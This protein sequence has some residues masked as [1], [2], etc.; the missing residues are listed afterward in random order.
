MARDGITESMARTLWTL[1]WA[2]AED[3]AGRSYPGQEL[4]QIAPETPPEAWDAALILV[5]EFREANDVDSM[6]ILMMRAAR[7]DAKAAGASDI[8]ERADELAD[9]R[10]EEEFG[11]CMAMEAM[12]HGVSW[13][14]THASFD[15]NFPRHPFE[16]SIDEVESYER[17]EPAA[18]SP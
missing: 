3:E 1:A 16:F 12:G 11:Y 18:P 13:F 6:Q 15:I 5:G 9:A 4:M 17:E 10:F 8:D 14:D 2:D 7:A